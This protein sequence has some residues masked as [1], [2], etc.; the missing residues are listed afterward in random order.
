MNIRLIWSAC[1]AA[2]V[3]G[4][5]AAPPDTIK[6]DGGQISGVTT[7]GVRSFLG[8]PF[9]AAPVGDLRWKPPQP[10]AP[11]QGVR[12]A[13][14]FGPQC[15]QG[16]ATPNSVYFEYS[17]GDLPMSEDCLTLNVWAPADATGAP[18]MVWIYGGGFQ[19]GAA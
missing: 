18:V 7:D 10:V 3:S 2:A 6:V 8:V 11:W 17:G 12:P 19:V 16:K 14:E 9:A 4:A 1:F 5:V 13:A 15:L